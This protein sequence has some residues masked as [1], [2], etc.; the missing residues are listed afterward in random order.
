[1]Q[2]RCT[3]EHTEGGYHPN[4]TET[5][6]SMK[7]GNEH[8]TDFRK[9]YSGAPQLYLCSFPAIDHEEFFPDFNHLRRS[10]ML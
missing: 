9:M 4:E 1:M 2:R 7:M 10:I 3:S 8:G 6:V 5:M